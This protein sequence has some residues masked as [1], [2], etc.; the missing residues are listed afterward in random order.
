MDSALDG[1]KNIFITVVVS[2]LL[3]L[4]S[5]LYFGITLWIIKW[6]SSFFFGGEL[7]ANWAVFSAAIMAT[8]GILAGALE[9]K[10]K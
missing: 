2:V 3:I 5:I 1:V 8:G 9:S 4:L 7:E 10:R 6:S